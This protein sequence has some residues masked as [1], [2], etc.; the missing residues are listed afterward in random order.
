VTR[1]PLDVLGEARTHLALMQ[2]HASG[3]LDDQLVID[4]A[5]A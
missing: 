3:A 4:A 5:L 1:D 2:R